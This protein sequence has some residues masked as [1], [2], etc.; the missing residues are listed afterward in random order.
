MNINTSNTLQPAANIKAMLETLSSQ[1]TASPFEF[2]FAIQETHLLISSTSSLQN[3]HLETQS[4]AHSAPSALPQ[5][6]FDRQDFHWQH[7]FFKIHL[8][9]W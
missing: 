5:P 1:N 9:S 8:K 7:H 3:Y 4:H 2:L 6:F